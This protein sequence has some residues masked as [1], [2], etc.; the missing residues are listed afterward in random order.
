MSKFCGHSSFHESYLSTNSS[1]DGNDGN[2]SVTIGELESDFVGKDSV[3]TDKLEDNVDGNDSVTTGKVD[4]KLD[5]IDS[6]TTGKLDK[7]V[8]GNDSL[9]AAGKLD[10]DVDAG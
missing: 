5:T 6:V 3:T 9:A 1:I 7:T 10:G 8:V 2:D 4:G